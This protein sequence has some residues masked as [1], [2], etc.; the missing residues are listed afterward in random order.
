M[1]NTQQAS[2][3]LRQ[4]AVRRL[5]N[6]AR[7]TQIKTFARRVDT[8]LEGGDIEG[9]KKAYITFQKKV[10]KAAKCRTI[11]PNAAARRKSRMASKINAAAK[12]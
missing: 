4:D 5:R 12:K 9:A 10:D 8:A 11:H 2:K 3:R 7:K 6:R 1:P